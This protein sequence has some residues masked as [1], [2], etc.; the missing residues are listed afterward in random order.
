M[1]YAAGRKVVLPALIKALKDNKRSIYPPGRTGRD[2]VPALLA[3]SIGRDAV[4]ALLGALKHK[5]IVV[6]ERAADALRVMGPEAEAAMPGLIKLLE[7][8]SS[9]VR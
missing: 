4:P 7:E 1:F 5:D 9:P 8:T 2:A 6:R 3:A